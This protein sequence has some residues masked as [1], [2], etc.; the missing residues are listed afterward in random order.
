MSEDKRE[1]LSERKLE[2]VGIVDNLLVKYKFSDLECEHKGKTDR[3]QQELVENVSRMLDALEKRGLPA[4]DV[5]AALSDFFDTHPEGTDLDEELGVAFAGFA[6]H[7][8][9]VLI[10]ERLFKFSPKVILQFEE[11]FKTHGYDNVYAFD[12]ELALD[13]LKLMEDFGLNEEELLAAFEH[14]TKFDNFLPNFRGAIFILKGHGVAG[15]RQYE[16]EDLE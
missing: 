7:V 16:R 9:D 4:N 15:L 6:D 12:L 13:I 2:P 11:V 3:I 10:R 14:A 5:A 8:Q 1:I